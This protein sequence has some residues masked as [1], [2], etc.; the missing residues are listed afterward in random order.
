MPSDKIGSRVDEVDVKHFNCILKM[1]PH[2]P[3]LISAFKEEDAYDSFISI[4]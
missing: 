3:E 4:V 2:F 1:H